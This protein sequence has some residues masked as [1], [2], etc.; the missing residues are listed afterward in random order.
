MLE[1]AIYA[2]EIAA[3]SQVREMPEIIFGIIPTSLLHDFQHYL[4]VSEGVALPPGE[5]KGAYLIKLQ[6][7]VE[8]DTPFLPVVSL[9]SNGHPD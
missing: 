3:K 8:Q 7:L 1:T 9:V 5:G 4:S 6:R 2:T